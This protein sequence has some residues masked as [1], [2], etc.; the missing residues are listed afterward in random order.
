MTLATSLAATLDPA[1]LA[2]HATRGHWQRAPHL[3][4]LNQRLLD[5]H[6]GQITRLLVT[7][8]PR[9]GKSELCSATYPAWWL[10]TRPDDRIILASYEAD[11]A[12]TWGRRARDLLNEHG[13]ALFGVQLRP[14]SQAARSFQL[15]EHRGSMT[16]AGAGGAITGRGADLFI[17]DDPHRGWEDANS[18]T[19]RAKVWDWYRS[20]ARTRLEPGGRIL[21]ITTRWHDDDLAGRLLTDASE[22][23]DS[24]HHLRLPALAEAEGEDPLDR[25]PGEP[26]WP[27]RFTTDDL[28]ATRQTLGSQLFAGLYQQAPRPA[29]GNIINPAW[30]RTH[31]PT[32]GGW[33]V[34]RADGTAETIPA[35]RARRIATVDLAISTT[36]RADYTVG[37]VGAI[38][39]DA[40][41][42]ITHAEKARLTADE[43]LDLIRRLHADHHAAWVGIEAT[44]Y[45]ASLVQRAADQGL[46]VR[47]LHADR[48]KV[49]RAMTLAARAE[50]GK[51]HLPANAAW[52]D[53]LEDEL[54]AFPNGAHD[55][56]VDA[57]AYLATQADEHARTLATVRP[58]SIK[59]PADERMPTGPRA[60]TWPD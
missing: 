48:D 13:Q 11:F 43:Q 27:Q 19:Q 15:A 4:L 5:L 29:D 53:D 36:S 33:Q 25:E 46:P 17:I 40:R 23:G 59:R 10:G 45:Q 3:D 26:L 55:D 7:M 18:A 8:P 37:I 38:T 60:A 20:V 22:G 31:Y 58:V 6:A 14:D 30:L 35:S 42:I 32:E 54:A 16:S 52:R 49:T 1:S 50:A 47:P 44:A 24:W 28:E 57:L 34:E 21:I 51:V 39:R 9:H 12:A 56:Q 2:A 41:I